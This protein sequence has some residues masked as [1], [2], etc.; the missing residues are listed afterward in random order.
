M[1]KKKKARALKNGAIG[2]LDALSCR[3]AVVSWRDVDFLVKTLCNRHSGF[4]VVVSTVPR[5]VSGLAGIVAT[6]LT[7]QPSQG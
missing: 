5:R 6:L 4:A 2:F 3:S 7:A 1:A